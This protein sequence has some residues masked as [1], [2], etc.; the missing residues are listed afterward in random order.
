MFIAILVLYMNTKLGY[1]EN[2]ATVLYH[3]FN[4]F[5][6]FMCIFGGIVSDVWLGKFNTILYLSIVYCIGS[7]VM[8]IGAIPVISFSPKI[9]LYI[10]LVLI[11][12]GSGGIKPCVSAFGGDQFK[13]PEQ[14]AQIVTYFSIFYFSINAGSLIST[15]I[16]P[17]L[18]ADVY[19]FGDNDCFPLAFGVP[20]ILMVVALSKF[21]FL[22]IAKIHK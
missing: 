9:A 10:S 18:R 12:F 16:T 14:A 1:S 19:C 13:M 11:A 3:V 15:T 6:Y 8:S 2:D 7:V 22:S 5:V 17:M 4:M 20:A 21:I